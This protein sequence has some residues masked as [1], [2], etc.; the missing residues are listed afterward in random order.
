M[1][2]HLSSC[3]ADYTLRFCKKLSVYLRDADPNWSE[4]HLLSLLDLLKLFLES[5]LAKQLMEIVLPQGHGIAASL[6]IAC[7]RHMC[8]SKISAPEAQKIVLCSVN[9]IL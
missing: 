7:K 3:E 8:S 2:V 1:H 4:D 6:T 5:K 9:M